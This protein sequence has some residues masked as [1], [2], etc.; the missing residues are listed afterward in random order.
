MEEQ[1]NKGAIHGDYIDTMK[2]RHASKPLAQADKAAIVVG[3]S[4]GNIGQAIANRLRSG[5]F[6]L[7]ETPDMSRLDVRWAIDCADYFSE[8]PSVDTLVLSHGYA[9]LDWIEDMPVGEIEDIIS[10]NL[11]GTILAVQA[12]VKATI[13]NEFRKRIVVIGSM[14]HR[15]VLNASAPYCAAKAGV[16]H[17]VRCMG[18]ELTPK[19]FDI[20][21][22]HP[23][24]TEDTPM[25]EKT[26]RELARF[27]DLNM[28]DARAYWASTNLMPRWLNAGDIAEVCYWLATNESAG[29]LSGQQIDLPG[30]VR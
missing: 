19:G 21:A 14:A 26:I 17:F 3:V 25:T 5:V 1:V 24:N 8:R 16:A 9:A 6:N 13:N 29:W 18:W 15:A 2:R 22:V 12:F 20:F 11:T 23:S 30:G 4:K 28:D 27:R 7:V 10:T